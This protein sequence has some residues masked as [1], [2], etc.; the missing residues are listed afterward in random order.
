MGQVA[1]LLLA[2]VA[3]AAATL[4]FYL[5]LMVVQ[6]ANADMACETYPQT[7]PGADFEDVR[8]IG[9]E[10]SW[11]NLGGRCAY[12]MSDGAVVHTREPGWS[13]SGTIAGFVA[14]VA[15]LAVFVV[16]RKGHLGWLYGIA[17]LLAPPLGFA[18]AVAAPRRRLIGD[19][20]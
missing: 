2:G 17:T 13:F 16:R 6:F 18:L 11:L 5:M 12:Y 15:G 8:G 9:F 14:I 3:G 10:N 20:S 4:V 7:V 1:K 19:P